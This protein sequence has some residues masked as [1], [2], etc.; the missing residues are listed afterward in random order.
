MPE[1]NSRLKAIV[2]DAKITCRDKLKEASEQEGGDKDAIIVLIDKAKK[3]FRKF[4]D[5]AIWLSPLPFDE[6]TLLEQIILLNEAPAD[7]L[8]ALSP[9][10]DKFLQ[11]FD[12]VTVII[13]TRDFTVPETSVMNTRVLNAMRKVRL[14]IDAKIEWLQV[15]GHD[16]HQDSRFPEMEEEQQNLVRQYRKVL[17][18]DEVQAQETDVTT[19]SKFAEIFSIVDELGRFMILYKAY[20]DAIKKRIP[21]PEE[22]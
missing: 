2:H 12:Q 9:A 3:V 21:E 13:I 16:P 20:N 18:K 14:S 10:V 1:N 8:S 4:D 15:N 6:S 5:A 22:V 7:D 11:A 19:I 17:I